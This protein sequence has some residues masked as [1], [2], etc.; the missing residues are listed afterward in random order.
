MVHP[1]RPQDI[2]NVYRQQAASTG[3]PARSGLDGL[4]GD[5]G[6]QPT[7]RI[8]RINISDE[9]VQLRKVLESIGDQ[10]ELREQRVAQLREQIASGTYDRGFTEIATRLVEEGLVQ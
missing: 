8:D 3:R 10:P 6:P 1:I 4:T 7:P 9:A 5:A 2:A